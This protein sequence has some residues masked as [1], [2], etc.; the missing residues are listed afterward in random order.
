METVS[1][2]CKKKEVLDF[3]KN[4]PNLDFETMNLIFVTIMQN[5]MQD[6]NSS[7]NSNIATQLLNQIQGLQNQ[8]NFVSENVV[9]LQSD[10]IMNF[11][12][13]FSEFKREYIDDVKMVLTNNTVDKIAPL[14]KDHN[15]ILLDKT[16]LMLNDVV[17]KNNEQLTK[18][19]Q[20]ILKVFHSSIS[21]E[22][23]QLLK[24]TINQQTLTDFINT[25]DNKFLSAQSNS[26]QI[27]NS[28]I[29]SSEHRLDSRI[30]E[31]KTSTEQH[32]QDIKHLSNTSQTS[33]SLLQN[34]VSELLK[35]MEISSVKGKCSENVLFNILQSLYSTAQ[36]EIVGDQ[37][38]TGDIMLMRKNKPTILIENKNWNKNVIQEEVKKF[39]RDVETQNCCGLFLSQNFGVANKENFEININNGNVL[40][41]VHEVNNDAEKIKIAID[42]IDNFK[43]KLDEVIVTNG[44]GYN[45]DK[46]VLDEINKEYQLFATHKL[47]QIKTVKDFSSKMVKQL[48]DLQLPSLEHF[49]STKYAFSSSKYIC[50]FCE[51]VAK[52]QS[53][54]SAHKR[55]CKGKTNICGD[56]DNVSPISET[57]QQTNIV[58]QTAPESGKRVSSRKK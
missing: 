28:I 1:L 10:T 20:E 29:T 42:I 53:A 24:S 17:P 31:I 51:Y 15:S 34:N 9:K 27:L 37:K 49:L 39:I 25:L 58:I 33:Q 4:H 12:A 35:K 43:I 52:N 40:L 3:Y 45:I 57:I 30:N 14:I 8:M 7:L 11:S 44:D 38:E 32:I 23:N 22:T 6:M 36:I 13:K 26:Q 41:Y 55:G 18:Q 2:I 48:E 47:L 16:Q 5:L 56:S 19:L 46:E 54:M 21:D 50:E